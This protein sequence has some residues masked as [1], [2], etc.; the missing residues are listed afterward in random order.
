[1]ALYQDCSEEYG[2]YD[3]CGRVTEYGRSCCVSEKEVS[4][5]GLFSKLFGGNSELSELINDVANVIK[6]ESVNLRESEETKTE[7]AYDGTTTTDFDTE[8]Y[9][10]G[11]D[12]GEDYGFSWGPVMP[13]EENQYNYN[14]TYKE[15]FSDVFRSTYP[16]YSIEDY[17]AHNGR[18]TVF[19]F[20]EGERKAL[21]VELLSRKSS[22]YKLRSD[23]K[24]EWIPYLR[25][26]YD[27]D[28]WWNTKEYVKQRT[29]IALMGG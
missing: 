11:R 14:G 12:C 19:V 25:F 2:D 13:D 29:R 6:Q 28:G 15:Y 1:M 8:V 27:F 17:E 10:S 18:T 21:V 3:C 20:R 16:M 5:T 24:A 4:A 22:A 9:A 26:Y 7:T 23:C